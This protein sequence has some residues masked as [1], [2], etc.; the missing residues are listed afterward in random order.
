MRR[1][2]VTG[3]SGFVGGHLI[4]R[5]VADGVAVRALARSERSADAVRAFGAEPVRGDLDDVDALRAGARGCD[6]AFHS[7]AHLGDRGSRAEF[8]RVNVG[9]T[10]NVL[11]GCTEA[12]VARFVHVG[13]EAA[14]LAGEPLVAADETLPLRPDSPAAYSA[15]KA[16]A[17]AAVLTF[18]GP[19]AVS[20]VRPRFVWGPRDTT[21][22]PLITEQVS[23]GKFAWVGGG[24]HRTSTTHVANAVEGLVRAA[25]RAPDGGVYFVTDG[26]PVVFR[27]FVSALVRTQGLEPPDRSLPVPVAKL[28]ARVPGSPLPPFALWVSTQECTLVDARARREL[29]YAPVVSRE[30][31]LR[32]L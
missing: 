15:T 4:E 9:G 5:L 28:L 3:G 22:L 12:G 26:E 1:A 23:S 32:D 29:G 8:E 14:L 20:V 21:L 13:T 11:R 31:G 25:D 30:D 27:E 7:A 2:F 24:R 17:E 16:R 19:M 18:P 10:L 6:V